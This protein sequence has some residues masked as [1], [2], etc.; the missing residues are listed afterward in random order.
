MP[1][2]KTDQ[3]TWYCTRWLYNTLKYKKEPHAV[4]AYFRSSVQIELVQE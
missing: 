2:Q 4:P 1:S 3:I